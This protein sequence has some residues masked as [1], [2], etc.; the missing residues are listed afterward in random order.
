MVARPRGEGDPGNL[1]RT[2]NWLRRHRRI[3]GG[4]AA[5]AGLLLTACSPEKAAPPEDGVN[6]VA[7]A[8]QAGS[9][10]GGGV[11]EEGVSSTET[12]TNAE[13]PYKNAGRA[14]IGLGEWNDPYRNDPESIARAAEGF[15]ADAPLEEVANEVGSVLT[16]YLLAESEDDA[17]GILAATVDNENFAY[18]L[19]ELRRHV[20]GRAQ[21]FQASNEAGS[22]WSLTIAQAAKEADRRVDYT[23]QIFTSST[24]P[25]EGTNTV[26]IKLEYVNNMIDIN[27]TDIPI[28][29][30]DYSTSENVRIEFSLKDGRRVIAAW[31]RDTDSMDVIDLY[32]GLPESTKAAEREEV[33]E[34]EAEWALR[35]GLSAA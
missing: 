12:E 31:E 28:D 10:A 1:G 25:E 7:A 35:H 18:Y 32:P 3:A 21:A 6:T 8:E 29:R 27:N 9:V 13:E 4:L 2:G 26:E 22:L 15:S 17:E 34:W 5:T 19:G 20:Q 14:T 24:S 30:P 33:L 23:Y 11:G 16:A